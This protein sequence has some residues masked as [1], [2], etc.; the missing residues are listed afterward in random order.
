MNAIKNGPAIVRLDHAP[1]GVSVPVAGQLSDGASTRSVVWALA[2]ECPVSVLYN[3]EPFAVMMLSPAD[4][5]DFA[6]GFSVT[7]G[8]FDRVS[9]IQSIRIAE[10]RDGYLVN[11]KVPE[12]AAARARD[13]SRT[14]PGRAGCGIC[15]SRTLETALPA[16]KRVAGQFPDTEAV[17]R[18]FAAF[19]GN[20]PMKAEN[21]STHAAAFCDLIGNILSVREDI[22]RHN[23]LDKLI[24]GLLRDGKDA[25]SGFVLL[26]S[27][28]SVEMAQKAAAI[29]APFV[30][31]VSAPSALAL[32]TAEKAGMGVAALCGDQVMI[33][34]RATGRSGK[35]ER[36]A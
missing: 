8:L 31:S 21:R 10:A 12:A 24:G 7:E 13:K 20:Q 29:G 17:L 28:F 4:L 35:R 14:L 34:D 19:E 30:A 18:A 6:V 16:P 27:R 2:E 33:F 23:A 5:E 3:G 1:K 26:S 15:G 32:R 25:A 36:V 11:I 22:G 9:E